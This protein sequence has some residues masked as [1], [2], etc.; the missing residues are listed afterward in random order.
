MECFNELDSNIC[1]R[2]KEHL[3]SPSE[4]LQNYTLKLLSLIFEN[5][6]QI[7]DCFKETSLFDDLILFLDSPSDETASESLGIIYN[8]TYNIQVKNDLLMKFFKKAS[9]LLNNKSSS[10]S[11]TS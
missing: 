7:L 10:L 3:K 1:L 9:T 4:T 11:H 2:L 8:Y 6:L 5:D